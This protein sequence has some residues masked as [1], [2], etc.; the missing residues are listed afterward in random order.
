M[1]TADPLRL[2]RETVSTQQQ[3]TLHA[4]EDSSTLPLSPD[5]LSKATHLYFPSSHTTIPLDTPTR[6]HRKGD[7]PLAFTLREVF[8]AWL[9]QAEKTAD[10]IAKCQ[11]QGIHHLT[12]LE[13]ADLSTWLDGGNS[14]DNIGM[15]SDFPLNYS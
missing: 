6:F 14:S 9:L 11:A 7:Q 12:F 1:A 8:F 15:F 5:S 2:L 13:K 3:P 4:S 10:Y